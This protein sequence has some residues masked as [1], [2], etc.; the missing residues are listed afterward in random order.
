MEQWTA[1]ACGTLRISN[2]KTLQRWID[3]GWYKEL[4][5]EGYIFAPYCGRFKTEICTCSACRNKRPNREELI[6]ILN[7][8][9]NI[10]QTTN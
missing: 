5:D 9:D 3:L 7:N 8:Y 1:P 2:P 6:N 10:N 4:I